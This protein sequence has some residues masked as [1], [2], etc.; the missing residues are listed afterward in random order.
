MS[1]V[2][3]TCPDAVRLRVFLEGRLPAGD[4]EAVRA[5]RGELRGVPVRRSKA[6][7]RAADRPGR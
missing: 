1:D 2:P 6:G 5:A 7:P 3:E 4:Q